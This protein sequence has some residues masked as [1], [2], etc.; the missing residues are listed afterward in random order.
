MFWAQQEPHLIDQSVCR[1]MAQDSPC[2]EWRQRVQAYASTI[3]RELPAVSTRCWQGM[4]PTTMFRK[5]FG[6]TRWK[7]YLHILQILQQCA[8]QDTKLLSCMILPSTLC[9]LAS[10][11]RAWT[12]C[13][14]VLPCSIRC[15]FDRIVMFI[16]SPWCRRWKI[17]PWPMA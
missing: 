14:T 4:I 6:F 9:I 17:I 11:S 12:T 13:C 16:D 5:E 8:S 15:S 10:V 1:A 7:G 2:I 3:S